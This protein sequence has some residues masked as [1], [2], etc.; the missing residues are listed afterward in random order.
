MTAIVLLRTIHIL[1]S[2]PRRQESGVLKC[3]WHK[4]GRCRPRAGGDPF[5]QGFGYPWPCHIV[6][7]RRMGPRLRGD[8]SGVSL[9]HIFASGNPERSYL[10]PH[11]RG[12]E[13]L[14]WRDSISSNH[15]RDRLTAP[16][17]W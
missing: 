8:D 3:P 7:L 12:G 14:R 13:R 6:L 15:A 16:A 2:F 5:P 4:P 1:R 17:A 10:G 9:L 11:F